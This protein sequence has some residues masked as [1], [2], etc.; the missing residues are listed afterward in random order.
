MGN[1][2]TLIP[3]YVF[4]Y[5]NDPFLTPLGCLKWYPLFRTQ[6]G[7]YPYMVPKNRVLSSHYLP[8]PPLKVSPR[9]H[10]E[11]KAGSFF[12]TLLSVWDHSVTTVKELRPRGLALGLGGPSCSGS[13]FAAR[14]S[15]E[16]Q[17]K[18]VKTRKTGNKRTC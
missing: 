18:K 9:A 15:W 13:N 8:Y 16:N 6:K 12:G 2:K 10:L 5:K 3:A 1:S 17:R 4:C 11:L 7:V 14:F